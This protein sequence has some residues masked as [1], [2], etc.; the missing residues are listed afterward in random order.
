MERLM[1]CGR[2]EGMDFAFDDLA[3]QGVDSTVVVVDHVVVQYV[4]HWIGFSG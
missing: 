3:D 4:S 1:G 2:V